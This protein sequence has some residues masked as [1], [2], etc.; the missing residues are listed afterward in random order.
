MKKGY[1]GKVWMESMRMKSARP[2]NS[3]EWKDFKFVF[4]KTKWKVHSTKF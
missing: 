4:N 2:E 3:I 1:K